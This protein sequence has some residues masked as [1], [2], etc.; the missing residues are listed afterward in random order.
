MVSADILVHVKGMHPS[1][2]ILLLLAAC[3][4]TGL[5]ARVLQC[6]G[7]H[8]PRKC[9]VGI[10]NDGPIKQHDVQFMLGIDLTACSDPTALANV[11]NFTQQILCLGLGYQ[12][13]DGVAVGNELVTVSDL[14]Q[15]FKCSNQ[16]LHFEANTIQ[17]VV[18]FFNNVL[19]VPT[20]FEVPP[21]HI[22]GFGS[23]KE[24]GWATVQLQ[25]CT[26]DGKHIHVFRPYTTFHGVQVNLIEN[27]RL[28]E[29][30]DLL[31]P[32]DYHNAF[33]FVPKALLPRVV[34]VFKWRIA[35]DA[36]S[37]QDDLSKLRE[38][39]RNLCLDNKSQQDVF[40]CDEIT[41][42]MV[43]MCEQY[44]SDDDRH[45]MHKLDTCVKEMYPGHTTQ[46]E[47]IMHHEN[48]KMCNLLGV[49]WTTPTE[50]HSCIEKQDTGVWEKSVEFMTTVKNTTLSYV[51]MS[52]DAICYVDSWIDWVVAKGWKL[53]AVAWHWKKTV[54]FGS[55]WA[56]IG[57]V[58]KFYCKLEKP[59]PGSSS[60]CNSIL[61]YFLKCLLSPL[62]FVRGVEK[63]SNKFIETKMSENSDAKKQMYAAEF[64]RQ[65]SESNTLTKNELLGVVEQRVS[66]VQKLH[67][68]EK[69]I[70]AAEF[71]RR[72]TESNTS[73]KNEILS[74]IDKKCST[75]QKTHADG[76]DGI[77]DQMKAYEH[78]ALKTIQEE[79]EAQRQ[80][81]RPIETDGEFMWKLANRRDSRYEKSRQAQ[82]SERWRP[83]QRD[84]RR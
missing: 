66:D 71:Q 20:C 36:A 68:H 4:N 50:L 69:E 67:Q 29:I 42:Q 13:L 3:I 58:Y 72:I 21:I 31:M 48:L 24:V 5:Q 56:L 70:Y 39:W 27:T 7:L 35:K 44:R 80:R 23:R 43:A 22:C 38:L 57:T 83:F 65:M 79:F 82:N 75:L 16:T 60:I 45:K 61:Y 18:D 41:D 74:V 53:F 49:E 47:E 28:S 40:R 12:P 62:S 63:D 15:K 73:T 64:Q 19:E 46:Q 52:Y 11:Q 76:V 32:L 81:G 17:Q 9:L 78:A 10:Q 55:F 6:N 30:S 54:T 1:R 33:V 59:T 51:Q 77:K 14:N 26:E 2:L 37:G 34:D 84:S 25:V 8:C